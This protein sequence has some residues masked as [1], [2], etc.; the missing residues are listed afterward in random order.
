MTTSNRVN[1]LITHGDPLIQIG[2]EGALR[3]CDDFHVTSVRDSR[4]PAG[5]VELTSTDVVVADLDIGLKL[6]VG[7]RGGTCRVLIVTHD[8]SEVVVRG[9]VEA[10]VRGY[11]LLGST[12]ESLAQAVRCVAR[13]GTAIDPRAVTKMLDSLNGDKLTDREV[14]VLRLV[15]LG[16]SNKAVATQLGIA[17]GTAK[18]HVKQLLSKLN[19]RSRTEVASIALRRGL[20]APDGPASGA[21]VASTALLPNQAYSPRVL[22]LSENV[23]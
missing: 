10:G 3:S 8:V 20:V 13:G 4:R 16:R 15:M 21:P 23:S 12:L 9:A 11:L 19:A 14:D 7:G 22:R 5:G 18:C 17:V 6:A 1:V 2:L